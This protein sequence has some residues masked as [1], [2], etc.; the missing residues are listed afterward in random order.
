[1]LKTRLNWFKDQL[2][3]FQNSLISIARARPVFTVLKGLMYLVVVYG[4]GTGLTSII[5][6]TAD[7]FAGKYLSSSKISYE[8]VSISHY[9]KRELSSVS[10]AEGNVSFNLKLDDPI[11]TDY[12]LAKVILKNEGVAIREPLK[13]NILMGN[14]NAK[15]LDIQHKVIAPANK[16]VKIANSLPS[17][18]WELPQSSY[19]YRLEW[20]HNEPERV[21]GFNVS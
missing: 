13:F 12:Y 8:V 15:I 7:F 3:S 20:D 14:G 6:K 18:T 21:S 19:P 11:L 16:L 9:N 5:S 17:L 2:K 10:E 1:M 4:L